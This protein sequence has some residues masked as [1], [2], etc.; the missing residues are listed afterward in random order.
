[1][2]G[3]RRDGWGTGAESDGDALLVRLERARDRHAALDVGPELRQRQLDRREG[4]RDVEDVEP[5]DVADAEDL[6]LQ[7]ALPGRERD[8]VPVAEVPQQL[9]AVDAVG[10]ARDRDD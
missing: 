3:H 8:A 5:A 10:H 1:T 6:P 4:G 2:R 7:P 9:G